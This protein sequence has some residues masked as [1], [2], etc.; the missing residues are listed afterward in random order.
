M[1][2]FD[3][4]DDNGWT[5]VEGN[6]SGGE[7]GNRRHTL[8]SGEQTVNDTILT[9]KNNT[10][11]T[12][13]TRGTLQ[14]VTLDMP[15][16]DDGRKRTIRIWLPEGYDPEDTTTRSPVLY[17]HDGQNLFDTYTAFSGEWCVDEAMGALMDDGYGGSIVVGI[18]NSSDRLNELS[19]SWTRSSEG[20]VAITNPSGE[21]Y[22]EFIVNTVKPYID[23]HFHTNP[24]VEATGIGGSSMGGVMSLFMALTYPW[25]FGYA[26]IFS[27]AMWVYEEGTTEAFIGSQGYVTGHTWPKLYIYAGGSGGEASITPYV[28]LIHDTLIANEYSPDAIAT[29]VDLSRGHN[30]NA[31][32]YYFPIA[33]Q[34]LVGI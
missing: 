5:Y 11:K 10:G 29:M 8:I 1:L 17:M 32:S 26:M 31:W 3:D 2:L 4:Q 19:P 23:S 15:Q 18:D 33:Y 30:E 16:Y 21:K 13:V 24:D 14:K 12:S 9:F 28:A 20:T 25:T 7:I 22:A 34:W 6:L 27:A